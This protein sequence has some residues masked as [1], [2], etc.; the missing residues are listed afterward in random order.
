MPKSKLLFLVVAALSVFTVPTGAA[1]RDAVCTYTYEGS[2]KVL[3]NLKKNGYQ[4]REVGVIDLSTD[5]LI[6]R[7]KD[8]EVWVF[9]R[10]IRSDG[11]TVFCGIGQSKKTPMS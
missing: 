6:Y 7:N 10:K 1:A 5:Q 11:S 8:S 9:I 4:L 3:K 2:Q